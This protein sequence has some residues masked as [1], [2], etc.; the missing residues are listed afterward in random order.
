M[1]SVE[2][3]IT[4]NYSDDYNC[5]NDIKLTRFACYLT[6]MNGNISN[7]RVAAAQAYFIAGGD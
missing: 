1:L 7:P 3:S 5:D 2:Y 4:E 6:V